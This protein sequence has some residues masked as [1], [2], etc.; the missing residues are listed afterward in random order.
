MLNPEYLSQCFFY[1]DGDFTKQALFDQTLQT[2]PVVGDTISVRQT[3]D[4]EFKSYKVKARFIQ[5][6]QSS[7][8]ETRYRYIV[9]EVK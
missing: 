6:T 1:A 3:R 5:T 8:L 7:A 4:R 2:A 9:K